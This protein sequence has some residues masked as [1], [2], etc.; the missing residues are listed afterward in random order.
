M[1]EWQQ[2]TMPEFIT[3]IIPNDHGAGDRPDAGYPFRESY[4]ADNDLAVGRIV[5]YLSHNTLLEKYADRD[6]RR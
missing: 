5:E 3:V 1:D 2:D 4:M 6:Y